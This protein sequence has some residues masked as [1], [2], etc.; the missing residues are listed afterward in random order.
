[1][2]SIFSLVTG[3]KPRFPGNGGSAR[4][5]LALQNIQVS[6]GQNH[7]FYFGTSPFTTLED[8]SLF[9]LKE[10]KEKNKNR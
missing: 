3:M 10:I 4:E 2:L 8:L 6:N 5:S 9:L 1:M 7:M